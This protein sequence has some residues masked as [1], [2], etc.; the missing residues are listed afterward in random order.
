[1]WGDKPGT[2][3]KSGSWG[4]D[5]DDDDEVLP[6]RTESAPDKDGI[7]TVVEWT[8]NEQGK[9]VKTTKRV[10]IVKRKVKVSRLS[11]ARRQWKKFGAAEG[12]VG[13]N[14][15]YTF[16][17]GEA[18]HIESPHQEPKNDGDDLFKQLTED[19]SNTWS[20]IRMKRK[21]R[22]LGLDDGPSSGSGALLSSGSGGKYVPPSR[23]GGGSGEGSSSR[24]DRDD[25]CTL[26]V[27][28]ISADANEQDLRELFAPFG[29]VQR[30]FLAKDRETNQS[31]GFAF[32]SFY[33]RS[34][35]EKALNKL[36]GYGYDHL[37]LRLEWARPSNRDAGSENVMRHASGYGKSLPQGSVSTRETARR[38]MR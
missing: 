37:I 16:V 25:S 22:E 31:R 32:V 35:A 11:R 38:S 34:D 12:D 4:D 21:Q 3:P 28:N 23:R 27:S 26:R 33:E 13:I 29:G 14:P 8:F 30:V 6:P 20:Q 7:K 36:Q 17:S 10:R 15:N 2:T 24:N 18:V 5:G 1:M 9:R 19:K